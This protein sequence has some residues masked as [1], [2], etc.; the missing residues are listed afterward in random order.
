MRKLGNKAS[1]GAIKYE[2]SESINLPRRNRLSLA[3]LSTVSAAVLSVSMASDARAQ[4]IPAE[5][6]QRG[7]LL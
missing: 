7:V 4:S 3:L 5:F 6:L 2:R 1:F